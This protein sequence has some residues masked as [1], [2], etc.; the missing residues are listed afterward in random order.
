LFGQSYLRAES[1]DRGTLENHAQRCHPTFLRRATD[2]EACARTPMLPHP[3]NILVASD[4]AAILCSAVAI[5]FLI[6]VWAKIREMEAF[7]LICAGYP[8]ISIIGVRAAASLILLAEAAIGVAL[9]I[10]YRQ[11]LS[12]GIAA[13]LVWIAA[14]SSV[15]A[16][17][18][19]RG[20]RK[21]RCGC[22]SDLSKETS[23]EWLLVRNAI[24]MAALATVLVLGGVKSVTAFEVISDL[25][26]AL[27]VVL[28]IYLLAAAARTWRQVREWQVLG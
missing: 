19:L 18:R 17:R 7:R 5:S 21:F 14:A 8:G 26:T 6:S 16:L 4:A 1:A 24:V 23:A 27:G 28:G 9:L 2:M 13:S 3:N 22:G 20:E 11:S 10:P 15:I 12:S 25:L